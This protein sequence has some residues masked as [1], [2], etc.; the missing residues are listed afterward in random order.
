MAGQSLVPDL[1]LFERSAAKALA[2]FKRF[3]MPDMPGKPSFADVCSQ[4]QFDLVEAIFGSYDPEKR[5][6]LINEFFVL[7][8]KKNGK[9]PT[10]AAIMLVAV[11]LNDRPDAEFYLIS[12]SH[13]I[14]NYSFRAIKGIIRAD[15][16]IE[17][18][19]QIQ[20]HLKRITHLETGA[21]LAIVSA[22]GD[23]VTGSKASGILIDEMH[24]LGAKPR[25]DQI[26]AELMGGFAARPE[27]FLLTITTQSKE[28][29][30]GEFKKALA[31]ARRVRDGKEVAR[32]LPILYEFPP[33]IMKGKR[34]RD[35]KIWG[36][37]NPNLGVSVDPGYL[38]EQFRKAEEDGPEALAL[39]ASL[40]LNVE[41]GVGLNGEWTGAALWA[42]AGRPGLTLDELIARCEVAVVGLDGGGL[43]DL[44]ALAVVGRDRDTKEWLCWVHAWAH[45]EVLQRRKEI[46]PHLHDF[47]K[48]GD[49]TLLRDDE[50][51][52]EIEGAADIVQRLHDAGLLPEK[53]SVGLD[54][55]QVSAMIDELAARGLIA[56]YETLKF[57]GQDWRLSPWIWGIERRL[58]NGT[59]LHGNQP[60]MNWVLGNVKVEGKGS[61]V[62]M[63]KEAAGRAKI[64]P[65]IAVLN[66]FALM[67]QNPVAVSLPDLD[68]WLS[69][70]VML[71]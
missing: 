62:R 46:S 63:T 14:A 26:M 47:A 11:L 65:M 12:A 27:G 23:I 64:D 61:A 39:F 58:K 59:F 44:F 69:N 50:P 49:L 3:R 5:A 22:D 70:P 52:G 9:T 60:M 67:S 33:S 31:R 71:A 32:L 42:K 68:G 53:R 30:V 8:P 17:K 29:P 28:P 37:V 18:L 51:T 7:V 56:D 35:P 16:D 34:W 36:A 40:H 13:Q 20:D 38:A 19:F 45:P 57:I 66:G 21:V 41:I 15:A 4:W 55:V 1:P 48:A 43:D 25:A 2:L 24:V 54:S 6:R 10:A